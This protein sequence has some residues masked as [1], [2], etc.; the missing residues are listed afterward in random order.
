MT[1]K[2]SVVLV[3]GPDSGKT[4]FMARLWEALQSEQRWL[5]ATETGPDIGYVL[6]ALTHLLQGKF[7]PRTGTNVDIEGRSC[8]LGVAWRDGR[9]AEEAELIVPDVSGEL[10]E[11]AVQSNELPEGWMKILRASLGAMMFVRVASEL[12][13]PSLDWVTASEL[14]Q[15]EAIG[16]AEEAECVGIP[17][18]IQLCELLRFL[19]FAL[20]QDADVRRPRVAVMI[21]AWDMVDDDRAKRGPRNYLAEEYPLFAGRLADVSV[22]EVEVYGVS[23]VGGDFED[24]GFKARFLAGEIREF[25]YVVAGKGTACVDPDVTAPICWILDGN[26]EQ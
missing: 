26:E 12:N 13:R 11:E 14:L 24:D 22:V 10:W 7:A 25:G 9:G 6:D 4:N 5:R 8:S 23:V 19:E 20:G 2:A 15:L 18:D 17:T 3:G 1:N 16:K 21:T